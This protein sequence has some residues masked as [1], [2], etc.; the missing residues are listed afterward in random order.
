MLTAANPEP[1]SID[2]GMFRFVVHEDPAWDWRTFD[3]DRDTS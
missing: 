2:V 1:G 3:L